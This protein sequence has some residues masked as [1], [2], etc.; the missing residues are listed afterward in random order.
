VP[1]FPPHDWASA[2][3]GPVEAWPQSLRT[4]VSILLN[5]KY[6]MF[7]GW[8]PELVFLYNDAYR[9]VLGATKHPDS[10]GRPT[11]EI[12]EEIWGTLGPLADRAVS[13]GEPTWSDDLVL[14]MNRYGYVE[15]TY[16]TFSYSPIRDETGGVGGMFCACTETTGKVL[17]ERRLRCL[18]DLATAAA[19]A[20]TVED[21]YRL[22]LHVL[23]PSAADIPFALL[24]RLEDSG[25]TRLAGSANVEPGAP[26]APRSFEDG[27]GAW[28]LERAA[29]G[30]AATIEDLPSRFAEVPRSIWGDPIRVA[31]I[32]PISDRGQ[33][34]A[35]AALVLG[36]S[37]RRGLDDDYRS[38]L[39]LVAGSIATAVSNA[40]AF[41][42]ERK[43][44]EAL[45]ELDRAKTAFFS[46]V[47]HEFRTPL[48]LMLG[49]LRR[50]CAAPPSPA[51]LGR[52]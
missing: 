4:A 18:R 42:A 48:T 8:G 34:K 36:V 20:Q 3:I 31:L 33:A 51:R 2:P 43:R 13:Q 28:P 22:C 25:P 41:E 30:D 19:E 46:N 7:I 6:P 5:S 45:A 10:I 29:R 40:R 15:E 32:L 52:S 1:D 37:P 16:F 26:A 44:A 35:S 47:S 38:F 39:D 11:R 17:G 23:E 14:M 50:R 12:W 21:T 24:Y 27:A 9:P 49:P